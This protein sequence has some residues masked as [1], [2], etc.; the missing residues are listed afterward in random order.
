MENKLPVV[1]FD[2]MAEESIEKVATG[3]AIGTLVYSE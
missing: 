1:V 2:L 3:E